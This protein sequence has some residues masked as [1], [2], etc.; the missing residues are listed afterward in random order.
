MAGG[1]LAL[2]AFDAPDPPI[3]NIS[4]ALYDSIVPSIFSGYSY[5]AVL[6][7][8]YALERNCEEYMANR[9]LDLISTI[10]TPLFN[11]SGVTGTVAFNSVSN[12]CNVIDAISMQ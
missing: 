4:R 5:D 11:F 6:T 9:T 10:T 3:F 12:M 8:A 2:D 1:V 7:Y